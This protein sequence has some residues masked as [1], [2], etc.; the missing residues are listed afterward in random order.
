MFFVPISFP[1]FA[2]DLSRQTGTGLVLALTLFTTS[3]KMLGFA[4]F[5][6]VFTPL[7]IEVSCILQLFLGG[8]SGV[9][10][11]CVCVC[12]CIHTHA[13]AHAQWGERQGSGQ[14][15]VGN[16]RSIYSD[17]RSPSYIN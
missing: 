15:T 2:V 3:A 8:L 4:F 12:V 17:Y 16:S 5:S 11:L 7:E 6:T 13:P 14:R 10:C 9:L 1:Y